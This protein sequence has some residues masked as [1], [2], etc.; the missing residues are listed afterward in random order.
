M[1]DTQKFT[2]V[3]GKYGEGPSPNMGAEVIVSLDPGSVLQENF[4]V[5]CSQWYLDS[6]S[7]RFFSIF[8]PFFFFDW[9]CLK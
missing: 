5:H 4:L 6:H 2:A 7:G 3:A 1:G 9:P 8:S